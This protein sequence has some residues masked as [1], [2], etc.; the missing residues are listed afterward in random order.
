M[1]AAAPNSLSGKFAIEDVQIVVPVGRE[2][3]VAAKRVSSI[4]TST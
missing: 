2:V 4:A 3:L 1:K